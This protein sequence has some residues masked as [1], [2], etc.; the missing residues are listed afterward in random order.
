VNEIKYLLECV[1]KKIVKVENY[2]FSLGT[3]P[4]A[5]DILLTGQSFLLNWVEGI[6]FNIYKKVTYIFLRKMLGVLLIGSPGVLII[7][8][9]T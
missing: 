9:K 8:H 6:S 1:V 2:T 7:L 4:N 3:I 5:V